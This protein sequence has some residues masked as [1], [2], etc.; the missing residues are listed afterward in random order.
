MYTMEVQ[1][2]DNSKSR[3]KC[4]NSYSKF[5]ISKLL[6]DNLDLTEKALIKIQGPLFFLKNMRKIIPFCVKLLKGFFV[7][8]RLLLL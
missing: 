5:D 3:K 8:Y 1:N 6:F 4:R 2:F 7:F